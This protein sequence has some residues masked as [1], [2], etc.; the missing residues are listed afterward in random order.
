MNIIDHAYLNIMGYPNFVISHIIVVLK[1]YT[2][3]NLLL[4]M[5]YIGFILTH[6]EYELNN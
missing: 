2:K 4:Y 3:P 6:L 1:Y 5:P